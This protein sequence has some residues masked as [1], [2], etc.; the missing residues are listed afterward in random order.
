MNGRRRRRPP[1]QAAALAVIALLCMAGPG[2]GWA[3]E[4]SEEQVQATM[5]LHV[6]M[7]VDWPPHNAPSQ[8]H[9]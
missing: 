4:V 7:L 1:S 3:P 2:H 8:M 5:L 9:I 6:L